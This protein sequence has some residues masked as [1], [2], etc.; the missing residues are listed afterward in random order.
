DEDE[1]HYPSTGDITKKETETKGGHFL[2]NFTLGKHFK[3][4]GGLDFNVIE[5][6]T[7]RVKGAPYFPNS[8][9]LNFGL[10]CEGRGIFLQDRLL[11]NGGIRY[12]FFEAKIKRTSGLTVYPRTRDF[13]NF[14]LRGGLV[15]KLKDGV[16]LK[17]NLG[18]G[19]RAPAPDELAADYINNWGIRYIGN[20]DL[21]PE[22]SYTFD[23]GIEINKTPFK[24]QSAY[25]MTNFKDKIITLYNSTTKTNTFHNVDGAE[26]HGWELN[27]SFDLAPFLKLPFSFEPYVDLTYHTKYI[28]KD[29]REILNYGTETLLYTPKGTGTLGVRL[30]GESWAADFHGIYMGKEKVIDWNWNSPTY[31]KAIKK[32]DF[33]IFNLGLRFSPYKHFEG[34]LK[35][36]NLFN[37]AYEYVPSYPMPKR[38]IFVGGKFKF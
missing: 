11:L 34:S 31:G 22:K 28:S 23:L 8:E 6:S 10:F 24:L 5:V 9:H 12:D 25:F 32:G 7:K 17:S 4:L 27:L 15:F 14:T 30:L 3:F 35:V 37:K 19:F 21:K 13:E 38:T 1:W 29:K 20:P 18:T 36:E 2:G 33:T 26:I 16:N